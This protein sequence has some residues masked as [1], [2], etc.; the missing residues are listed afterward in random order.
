MLSSQH[1]ITAQADEI[2]TLQKQLEH[3][4]AMAEQLARQNKE[5]VRDKTSLEEKVAKQQELI[6]KTERSHLQEIE[7]IKLQH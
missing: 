5:L 2:E 1:T 6:K 7:D 4:M 3:A